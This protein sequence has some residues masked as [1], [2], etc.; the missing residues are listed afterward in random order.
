MALD[1]EAE[2]RLL[3]A[4]RDDG[5]VRWDD[6]GITLDER[7]FLI[8]K[9]RNCYLRDYPFERIFLTTGM[10]LKLF[11]SYQRKWKNLK[12]RLDEQLLLQIR[13]S[14][15]S[16]KAEEF[17]QRGLSIGLRY[18]DRIVKRD[19]ELDP[20]EFKLIMD[21][22]LGMHRVK[23]LE[24]GGPTDISMYEKMT[25]EELNTYILSLREEIAQEYPEILGEPQTLKELEYVERAE[26]SKS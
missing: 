16:D 18:L 15:I 6:P 9:A 8:R 19:I 10:P 21:S 7:R 25:P 2:N 22:V 17:V 14:A 26:E 1:D 4:K 5:Q 23:Q 3:A 24:T 13:A 11:Y 20:K 12:E